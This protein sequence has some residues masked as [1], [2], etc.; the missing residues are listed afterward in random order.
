MV[1][2]SDEESL[3]G[4]SEHRADPGRVFLQRTINHEGVDIRAFVVGGRVLGAMSG[5]Q[6]GGGPPCPRGTARSVVLSRNGAPLAV[7]AAAA[8]GADYAG[9][10]LWRTGRQGLVMEVNGIPGW[11][12]LQGPPVSTSPAGWSTFSPF[13]PG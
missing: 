11:K 3:P 10:D 8:V 9:I 6:R 4:I 13:R 12:G 5:E 1:R 2:V 7:R